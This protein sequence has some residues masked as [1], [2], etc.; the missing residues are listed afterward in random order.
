MRGYVV[1]SYALVGLLG[2]CGGGEKKAPKKPVDTEVK[3]VAKPETEE[4]RARK[5]QEEAEAIVP[6]G[7]S[8]LPVALK[9]ENAPRLELGAAGRDALVCAF[10]QDPTRLLGPVACW[11]L[12]VMSGKLEYK[13]PEPLPGR[14]FAVLL[15]GKC[16][17]GYCL[18]TAPK[19]N[20]VYIAHNL[21]NSKVA[22]LADDEVHIFNAASKAHESSFSIRGDKGVT[23]EPKAVHFVGETILVEGADEG[24]YSAVWVF[25]TDGTK[26]G[27]ITSLGSKDDKPVSTYHGSFSILDKTR[28]ALGEK[29]MEFLNAYDVNTGARAKFVRK[30]PKLACKPAEL[31]AYWVDGDKVTDKC[32]EGIQKASG[33]LMGATVVAGGKSLLVL[34]RGDRLG[35]LAIMDNKSLAEKS[36]LDM[37]WC[38]GAEMKKEAAA[39]EK[40]TEAKKPEEKKPSKKGTTRG[41]VPADSSDPQEGG[42]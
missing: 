24:P 40:K 33:P 1:V 18:P 20:K 13:D 2:A 30:M 26:L 12:D 16:A 31:D 7:S 42:E 5:R 22:V 28:V 32:K 19:S 34:L 9:E 4:D 29:G 8:C 25:K 39:D 17:R 37:P 36:K 11:K 38:E 41:A 35:Q 27:P 21:D 14:G 23:N 10:D 6:K 15:D 3:P